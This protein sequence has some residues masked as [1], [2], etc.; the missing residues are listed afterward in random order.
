MN[1]GGLS[2]LMK[3]DGSVR[4]ALLDLHPPRLKP[5]LKQGASTPEQEQEIGTPSHI[6]SPEASA[7]IGSGNQEQKKIMPQL[8]FG[9]IPA[10]DPALL[11]SAS[12]QMARLRKSLDSFQQV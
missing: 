4:K 6:W 5:R 10:P 9:P 3:V 8:G 1:A 11:S 2:Q 12:E 7:E